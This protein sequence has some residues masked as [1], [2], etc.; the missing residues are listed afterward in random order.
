MKIQTIT[1]DMKH[2]GSGWDWESL[3]KHLTKDQQRRCRALVVTHMFGFNQ[4]YDEM[5]QWCHDNDVIIFED[6]IQGYTVYQHHGHPLAHMS[7]FS[8]GMDKIPCTTKGGFAI[9][10]H[11]LPKLA[12]GVESVILGFPEPEWGKRL[13]DLVSQWAYW[14]LVSTKLGCFFI[15]FYGLVVKGLQH[16]HV[17]AQFIRTNF[18][19]AYV[20]KF[21]V[22][23]ISW[24]PS[25]YHLKSML[26]GIRRTDKFWVSMLH[27]SRQ[28][29]REI[30][31]PKYCKIVFPWENGGDWLKEH[32][33][34][35]FH[36][37]MRER[38]EACCHMSDKG[39]NL[40]HQQAWDFA[41]QLPG[42]PE[43]EYAIFLKRN[44]TYFALTEIKGSDQPYDPINFDGYYA[45]EYGGFG[46]EMDVYG[47]GGQPRGGGGMRG[48]GGGRGGRG[49]L[50]GGF[51]GGPPSFG[52]G[53]GGA[54][55]RGGSFGGRGGYDEGFGGRGG[56]GGNQRGGQRGGGGYEVGFNNVDVA[57]YN[58]G[59]SFGNAPSDQSAV[60][61]FNAGGDDNGEQET[62]Q[63]TIPKDMAGAII[64]P[65]GSRIR[66]IR[67]DSK[68]SI[69]IDEPVQ[70]SNERIITITGSQRQIQTAQFLLQQSV[71]EHA[72]PPP[73]QMAYGGGP[74]GRY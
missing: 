48:S 49:G 59:N 1:L 71:R 43:P 13:K 22:D 16:L 73:S 6:C 55:A 45:S 35:Y 2:D 24:C 20:G 68:A 44:M 10:R 62:T 46:T 14:F 15:L 31:G 56:F 65:G 19:K 32:A 39:W 12:Q 30:L 27:E 63:V 17:I 42:H 28:A 47:G 60:P 25:I 64:G 66:G 23:R 21:T 7:V 74:P 37:I 18:L 53:R 33:N 58:K 36:C 34:L 52:G 3:F 26:I 41:A 9:V 57:N 38:E 5:A 11:N 70:G 69:T 4:N 67:S 29:F 50:N 8:G 72:G 54:S 40:M 51:M 61:P